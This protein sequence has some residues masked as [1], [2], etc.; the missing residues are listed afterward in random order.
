M[1]TLESDCH[2]ENTRKQRLTPAKTRGTLANIGGNSSLL[3]AISN[4]S[5]IPLE[6]LNENRNALCAQKLG[7]QKPMLRGT[8][9]GRT[10]I[11]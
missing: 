1:G 2:R 10:R 8:E 9:E 5:T 7:A 6:L 11:Q 4:G 3:F